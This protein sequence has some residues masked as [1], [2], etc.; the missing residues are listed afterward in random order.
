MAFGIKQ[1]KNE[2]S[3]TLPNKEKYNSNL[4]FLNPKKNAQADSFSDPYKEESTKK[5][6]YQN[7]LKILNALKI[8]SPIIN[9]LMLR[10]GIDSP[11]EELSQSFRTLIKE[12]STSSY[13]SCETF[14]IDPTKENNF[15][16]RNVIEKSFAEI[17]KE[18]WIEKG[19]IQSNQL[20]EF[21]E[22]I[23]SYSEQ[24]ASENYYENLSSL[25]LVKLANFKAILPIL[26][27]AKTHFDLYRNLEND[28]EPIL[29]KL[30]TTTTLAVQ[31]L[32][33]NYADENDRAKIFYILMQ[34]AGQLYKTSWKAESI[35]VQDIL[36]SYP[37][38]KLEKSLER[39]KSQGGLPLDKVNHDFDKYFD[40]ILV[41]TEKLV[42]SQESGLDKKLKNKVN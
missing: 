10:P 6:A 12:I 13:K 3:G 34:E 8:V 2:E 36:K 39:H 15:W 7:T 9:A 32:A 5:A 41:I 16:I 20:L 24:I 31:K 4:E 37:P 21:L 27:E 38:E 35:R 30:F 28:I 22:D 42:S 11:S 14:Q 19:E 25:E 33:D 17:F 26:N 18:Q 23:K 40:K 29:Q 1:A